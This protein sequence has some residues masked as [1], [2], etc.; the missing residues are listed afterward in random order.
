MNRNEYDVEGRQIELPYEEGMHYFDLYHGTELKPERD[1]EGK[2]VLSFEMEAHGY[3]A[4]LATK[5]GPDAGIQ[6]LMAK[7]K[8]MTGRPWRVIRMN[9]KYYRSR[10]CPSPPPSRLRH[11]RQAW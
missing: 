8:A 11:R 9:G 5:V 2:A 7:M 6:A 10:L 3:G 4:L 1:S